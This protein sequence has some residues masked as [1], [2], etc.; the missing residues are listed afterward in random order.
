[1]YCPED[2][3]KMELGKPSNPYPACPKCGMIL[4]YRS[5]PQGFEILRDSGEKPW[6]KFRH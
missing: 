5:D 3:T 4:A 1:M 2:G 6:M